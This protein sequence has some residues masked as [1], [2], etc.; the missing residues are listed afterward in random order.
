MYGDTTNPSPGIST[1]PAGTPQKMTTDIPRTAVG[2]ARGTSMM[3]SR[4]F[5]PLMRFLTSIHAMGSP[6]RMSTMVTMNAMLNEF[7]TAPP[8]VPMAA[9]SFMT[10]S[11]RSQSV[12]TLVR[13]K[14]EGIRI[15]VTKTTIAREVHA[16]RALG[17]PETASILLM[18]PL[19]FFPDGKIVDERDLS[20]ESIG[21]SIP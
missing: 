13:T 4:Y 20:W 18:R 21:W 19:P 9:G 5:L 15:I 8:M 6:T 14:M 12:R 11:T 17:L 16:L 1:P 10:S 3:A 7:H 2:K